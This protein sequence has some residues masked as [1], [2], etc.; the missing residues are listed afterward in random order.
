MDL[1]H[2]NVMGSAHEA[3]KSRAIGDTQ[4]QQETEQTQQKD[5][6]HSCNILTCDMVGVLKMKSKEL[7]SWIVS[8]QEM[9]MRPTDYSQIIYKSDLSLVNN[10]L[11]LRSGWKSGMKRESK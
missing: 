2:K 11:M 8:R 6:K 1:G 7:C 4:T 3:P 10:T 5:R 9:G